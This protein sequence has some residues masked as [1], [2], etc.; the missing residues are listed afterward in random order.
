MGVIQKKRRALSDT[1][2]TVSTQ[3]QVPEVSEEQKQGEASTY[4]PIETVLIFGFVVTT[5]VTISNGI[6][7]LQ[8]IVF[9]KNCNE[10]YDT[11]FARV[12]EI[13]I[14]LYVNPSWHDVTMQWLVDA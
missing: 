3:P 10:R 6:R 9:S 5:R 13:I 7:C 14:W 12:T 8:I 11:Y 4:S 2:D 1:P